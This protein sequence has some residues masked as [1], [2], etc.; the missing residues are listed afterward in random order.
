MYSS[1]DEYLRRK[2]EG[3]K[4]HDP[5]ALAVAL[6]EAVC[7]LKEVEL[8]CREGQWGSNLHPGTGIWISVAYSASKFQATL[9]D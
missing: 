6:D 4:L 8:F 5:L 7:E 2:P 1:M 9:L 3:K